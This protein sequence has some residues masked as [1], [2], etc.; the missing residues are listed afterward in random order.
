MFDPTIDCAMRSTRPRDMLPFSVV[1]TKI[2]SAWLLGVGAI[3]FLGPTPPAPHS[4][5]IGAPLWLQMLL[6]IGAW[7]GVWFVI[8][9]SVWYSRQRSSR[10][11]S[12]D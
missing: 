10:R 5:L 6:G 9:A 8:M 7:T 12:S 3:V 11:K 2:V 4:P 1:L